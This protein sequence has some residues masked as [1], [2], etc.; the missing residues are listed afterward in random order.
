MQTCCLLDKVISRYLINGL[1]NLDKDKPVTKHEA[2]SLDF[3]ERASSQARLFISSESEN[4]LKRLA[5]LSD[6]VDIIDFF[7]SDV[8]IAIPTRYFKRWSRRLREFGFTREDAAMI[9][10]ATFS[11]DKNHSVLGMKYLA[12]YDQPMKNNWSLHKPKIQNR[13]TAMKKDIPKFYNVSLPQ[14]LYP[15]NINFKRR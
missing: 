15:E 3:L 5:I 2:L 14:I 1:I 7:L 10:L 11:T 4:I 13:L 8:E 6:Y 9:A 12:T